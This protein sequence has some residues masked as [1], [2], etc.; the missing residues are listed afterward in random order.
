MGRAPHGSAK[1]NRGL[2][3]PSYPMGEVDR[4]IWA[5]VTVERR[6]VDVGPERPLIFGRADRSDD[7]EDVIGLDPRD[8]AI[9]AV[10][11]AVEFRSDDLCVSNRSRTRPLMIE[12]PPGLPMLVLAPGWI[13][14]VNSARSTILVGGEIATHRLVVEISDDYCNRVR[15]NKAVTS[16]TINYGHVELSED[17]RAVLAALFEGY[18]LPFPYY[19]PHPV[20]YAQAAKRLR[21][22][23]TD[24]QVRKQVERVKTEKMKKANVIIEGKDSLD[25]MARHL[26]TNRLLTPR[27]LDRLPA[28][29]T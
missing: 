18:L 19:S 17:D 3:V 7:V 10:A 2:P 21:S 5:S 15:R 9:S 6:R 26:I 14:T 27:D 1:K 22:T 13:H 23:R 8:M 24:V 20:T 25:D 29:G 28:P 12:D 16:G 11:G 4:A